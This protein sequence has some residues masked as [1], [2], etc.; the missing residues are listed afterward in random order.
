M[1]C[2][3]CKMPEGRHTSDCPV[4]LDAKRVRHEAVDQRMADDLMRWRTDPDVGMIIEATCRKHGVDGVGG[5]DIEVLTD[6]HDAVGFLL[7]QS[8]TSNH[9]GD[10]RRIM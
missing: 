10:P 7:E 5:L 8:P 4:R 3:Q 2:E 6:L 1:I 9:P